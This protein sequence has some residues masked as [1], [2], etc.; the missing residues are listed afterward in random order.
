MR[1]ARFLFLITQGC[2]F[3]QGGCEPDF[4]GLLDASTEKR[5]ARELYVRA[6]SEARGG[7]LSGGR[8]KE[9]ARR[10]AIALARKSLQLVEVHAPRPIMRLPVLRLLVDLLTTSDV[11]PLPIP[12]S[13]TLNSEDEDIFKCTCAS[14]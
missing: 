6:V 1:T 13:H 11:P 4:D 10:R 9:P 3:L 12:T 7:A 14:E 5:A 2:L 8:L